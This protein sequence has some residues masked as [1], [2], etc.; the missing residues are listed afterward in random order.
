MFV[1]DVRFEEGGRGGEV[2]GGQLRLKCHS[3]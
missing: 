1:F 3:S 2:V